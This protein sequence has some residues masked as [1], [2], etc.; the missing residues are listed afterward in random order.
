MRLLIVFFFLMILA[1]LAWFQVDAKW[2]AYIH[3]A[4]AAA[5][6]LAYIGYVWSRDEDEE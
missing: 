1:G 4:A 3:A 5:L 2:L 6:F